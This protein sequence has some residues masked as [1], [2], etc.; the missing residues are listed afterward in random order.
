[1]LSHASPAI[2]DARSRSNAASLPASVRQARALDWTSDA[3]SSSNSKSPGSRVQLR[4][5]AHAATRR[6]TGETVP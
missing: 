2:S 3:R 6:A 5:L 1:M 4:G